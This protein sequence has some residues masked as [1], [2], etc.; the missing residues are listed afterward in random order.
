MRNCNCKT[1]DAALTNS[2]EKPQL[3]QK[4]RMHTH[5]A[6]NSTAVFFFFVLVFFFPTQV[7][8]IENGTQKV[9]ISYG[10]K[11]WHTFSS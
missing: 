10:T 6:G 2:E 3:A 8:L 5:R 7:K 1:A 11:F 4:H 9:K